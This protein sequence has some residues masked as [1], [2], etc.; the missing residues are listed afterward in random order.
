MNLIDL[1]NIHSLNLQI[2][3]D[4]YE[5]DFC[6]LLTPFICERATSFLQDYP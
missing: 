1:Q 5:K 6:Y 4:I 2:M 3:N